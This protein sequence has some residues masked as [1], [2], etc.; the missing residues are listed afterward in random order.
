MVEPK[1]L[2]LKEVRR[3]SVCGRVLPAIAL[4]YAT[5]VQ[6]VAGI[7]DPAAVGAVRVR[8]ERRPWLA[9]TDGHNGWIDTRRA[10]PLM[11]S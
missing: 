8:K 2:R 1:N 9:I 4:A 10:F 7:Q 6:R 5:G 11:L 3:A